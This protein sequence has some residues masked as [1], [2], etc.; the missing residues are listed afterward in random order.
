MFTLV[1]LCISVATHAYS[2]CFEVMSF[3]VAWMHVRLVR[4]S[5]YSAGLVHEGV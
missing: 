1:V 4:C 2:M 5:R 3:V